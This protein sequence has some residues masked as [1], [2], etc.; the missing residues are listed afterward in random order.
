MIVD[1]GLLIVDCQLLSRSNS[2]SASADHQS[3]TISKSTIRNQQSPIIN[4]SIG[5]LPRSSGHSPVQH[6]IE[7]W[8]MGIGRATV[9][10]REHR[11]I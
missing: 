11:V 9:V 5:D 10:A 4:D 1:C 7:Q 8:Q 3:P 2:T 6:G